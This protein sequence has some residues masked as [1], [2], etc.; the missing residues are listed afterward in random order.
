MAEILNSRPLALAEVAELVKKHEG[1]ENKLTASYL[2]SF[3]SL[4]FSDGQ[5]IIQKLRALD[6]VKIKESHI[7]KV[8]DFMPQDSEDI[9]KIFSD[10]SLSEE[11]TQAIL[12][13]L[14]KS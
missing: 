7:V 11:E 9:N 6:N 10:V 8:L 1:F 5:E 4:K 3:S 13:I 12:Q 14:R 2:K